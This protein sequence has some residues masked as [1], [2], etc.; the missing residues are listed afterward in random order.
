M[1]AVLSLPG[2]PQERPN[3]WMHYSLEKLL[4]ACG[5]HLR[6]LR[7]DYVC[8][9]P[10][11]DL[12][13]TLV[14]R[15]CPHLTDFEVASTNFFASDAGVSSPSPLFY[16]PFFSLFSPFSSGLQRIFGRIRKHCSLVSHVRNRQVAERYRWRLQTHTKSHIPTGG[17]KTK[18]SKSF[19]I[20][21]Y[22]PDC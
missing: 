21:P 3:P 17:E 10:F 12:L 8:Q 7:L 5:P 18:S 13:L 6:L 14:P 4:E 20:L 22:P 9:L 2:A 19:E 15:H 11:A 1:I 16:F